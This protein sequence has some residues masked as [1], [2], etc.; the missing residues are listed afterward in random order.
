MYTIGFFRSNI[1]Y[2]LDTDRNKIVICF[3]HVNATIS[4][5][6]IHNYVMFK[7]FT[8]TYIFVLCTSGFISAIINIQDWR[9]VFY[10]CYFK[11][12]TNQQHGILSFSTFW[13]FLFIFIVWIKWFTM[14]VSYVRSNISRL[15]MFIIIIYF[16]TCKWH[17]H[18]NN[19]ISV[20]IWFNTYKLQLINNVQSS[21]S[22]LFNFKLIHVFNLII[23]Y[24]KS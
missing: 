19:V 2:C 3:Q 14:I 24:N 23:I 8:F 20:F 12:A 7:N 10:V 16:P 17:C 18:N 15:E 1:N 5:I 9:L 22:T 21:F 11:V 6:T 13:P 4:I